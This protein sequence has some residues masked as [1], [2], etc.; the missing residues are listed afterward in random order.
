ML[1]VVWLLLRVQIILEQKVARGRSCDTR[2]ALSLNEGLDDILCPLERQR[3][4][5]PRLG[6]PEHDQT[7]GICAAFKV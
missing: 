5:D 7:F 2:F 1:D 3:A 4:I 6:L